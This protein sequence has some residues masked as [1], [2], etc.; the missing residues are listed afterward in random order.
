MF[1][2][3]G[4][5]FAAGLSELACCD[6]EPGDEGDFVFGAVLDDILVLAVADVVLI[7]QLTIS[8]TLRAWSIS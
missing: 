8:T 6:R 5:E 2:R 1:L 7:L 4:V 3:S